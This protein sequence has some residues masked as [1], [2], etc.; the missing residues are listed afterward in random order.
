MIHG[1]T[2]NG[3][4]F[5]NKTKAL[6]KHLD[7]TFSKR[8]SAVQFDYPTAPHHLRLR[9]IPGV[10]VSLLQGGGQ[11]NGQDD[12]NSDAYAWWRRDDATGEYRGFNECFT[13]LSKYLDE[14][15][16]FDGVIGFSQGAALAAILA[17]LLEPARTRPAELGFTTSHPPMAFAVSY[18]G[19]RAPARYE[20]LYSPKIVTP[21]LHIIGSL[22]T[23]VE[24]SRPLALVDACVDAREKKRVVYHPG[25]HYVVVQ[26]P[27]LNAVAGFID[28][29]LK[30][31]EQNGIETEENV[32]DMDVPF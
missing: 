18:C 16:P 8:Y 22:D 29:C 19:F 4:L 11:Q 27:Y 2:Q 14:H 5:N 30:G 28:E 23:V 32:E 15:G 31:K 10:D 17:S 6:S 26:K 1:Y 3:P 12:D 25:G 7:K 9:D 21:V 20:F 24:E 13:F